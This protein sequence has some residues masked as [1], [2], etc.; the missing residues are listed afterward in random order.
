MLEMNA[1]IRTEW[2]A[3]LRSGEYPQ[4]HGTLHRTADRVYDGSP[5]EGYCCMGVLTDLYVKAGN[6]ETYERE[7]YPSPFNVWDN[8]DLAPPVMEWAGLKDSNPTFGGTY[9]AYH[10]DAAKRSFSEIADMIDGGEG[11]K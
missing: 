4:T 6:S 2:C 5:P 3:G 8:G 1:E 9:A 11:R 10:N 7:G